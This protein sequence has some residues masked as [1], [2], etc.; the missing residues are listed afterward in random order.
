MTN[1]LLNPS[2]AAEYLGSTQSTLSKWRMSGSGPAYIKVGHQVRYARTD[3]EAW[4]AS[5]R[6]ESTSHNAA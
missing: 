5:C 6:R 3:L 2:A 1:E 4:V